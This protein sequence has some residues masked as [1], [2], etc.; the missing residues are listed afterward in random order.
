MASLDSLMALLT[1]KRDA[2]IG[3]VVEAEA[4]LAARIEDLG[5]VEATIRLMKTETTSKRRP[6]RQPGITPLSQQLL[7]VMRLAGH[8][9]AAGEIARQV[10]HPTI[11]DDDLGAKEHTVGTTLRRLKRRGLVL[12]IPGASGRR[13]SL[14]KL[15][16]A[17]SNGAP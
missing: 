5:H 1:K 13:A 6:G 10:K 3:A 15:N 16:A 17:S 8:P 4:V 11:S 2:L 12:P 14:W 7:T 9:L